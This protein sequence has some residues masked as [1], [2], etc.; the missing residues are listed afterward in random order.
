MAV[1]VDA[2]AA[3]QVRGS[4]CHMHSYGCRARGRGTAFWAAVPVWRAANPPQTPNRK[5]SE[6]AGAA[7]TPQPVH[8]LHEVGARADRPQ[9]RGRHDSVVRGGSACLRCCRS[10]APRAHVARADFQR[11]FMA[12]N[13]PTTTHSA[14]RITTKNSPTGTSGMSPTAGALATPRMGT[15][16]LI[17]RATPRGRSTGCRARRVCGLFDSHHPQIQPP[18]I[19]VK[20]IPYFTKPSERHATDRRGGLFV[21]SA[22]NCFALQEN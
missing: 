16:G 12:L 19:F 14:H 22:C 21:P 20:C 9:V 13:S 17:T 18:T 11:H 15:A 7:H 3:L 1:D 5:L 6:H 2:L 8:R 4:G 10:R